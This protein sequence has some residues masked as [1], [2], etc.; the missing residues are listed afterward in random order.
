MKV[1]E[2]VS[3]IEEFRDLLQEHFSLWC[4]SLSSSI[5]DK[6]VRNHDELERQQR[7]L[8][9]LF[10]VLDPYLTRFSKGRFMHTPATGVRWDIYRSAIGNDTAPIKGPS[11]KNAL[12]ELEGIL[13]L[14]ARKDSDELIGVSTTAVGVPKKVF[15][16]HG[17]ETTA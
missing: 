13:A 11:A 8:F 17:N 6:P 15:I 7:A 4:A 5:P 10:Y 12:L 2:L 9:R 1:S 14:L 16:S 3:L